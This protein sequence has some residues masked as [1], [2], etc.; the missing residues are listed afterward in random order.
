MFSRI[1][2]L[3]LCVGAC[4]HAA[5]VD[6]PGPA[7]SREFGAQVVA[8]PN[9][10]IVVADPR[11]DADRGAVHLYS[12]RGE[13]ISTL[14]GAAAGDGLGAGDIVVLPS[15]NFLIANQG[16]SN[17]PVVA[18][19]SVTWVNGRS[20]LNGTVSSLNSLVGRRDVDRVGSAIVVLRNG[21]YLVLSPYWDR[22]DGASVLRDAGALTWGSGEA[23]VA[24]AVSVA[25]S[26]VGRSQDDAVGTAAVELGSGHVAVPVPDWDGD[27]ARDVGAVAW[28]DGANG[29]AGEVHAGNALIGSHYGD[30]VGARLVPL[31]GDGG[32]YVA[33]ETWGDGSAAFGALTWCS[34]S[35]PC[36]DTV[37]A[38]NSIIGSTPGDLFDAS[39]LALPDGR[40]LAL[41]PGWNEPSTQAAAAGAI[42][43]L[44]ADRS[45]VGHL[46]PARLLHGTR[47]GDNIG[48]SARLLDNG[49]AVVVSR[50]RH[51]GSN[52]D[53][54]MVSFIDAAAPAVG[55][56]SEQN[57][58]VVDDGASLSVATLAS[59]RYVVACPRCDIDGVPDAGAVAWADSHGV[60][61]RIG[62]GNALH[63]ISPGDNVGS[64]V[65]ALGNGNYVVASPH[66]GRSILS[67]DV[68]AAT[69]V[70]GSNGIARNSATRGVAVS[71]SNS[72]TG[73]QRGDLVGAGAVLA[74]SNGNYV[75]GS[76]HWSN[77]AMADVGAVTWANGNE[78][79]SGVVDASNSL[80]GGSAGDRVGYSV[81]ALA[82]GNYAVGAP[83]WDEHLPSG[84]VVVDGGAA[85]WVDGTR[86][87]TGLVGAGNA[88]LSA[89]DAGARIGRL[90]ALDNGDYVVASAS[91]D[92]C[93][94]A[95]CVLDAGAWT[96]GMA[97]RRLRGRVGRG[98]SVLGTVGN[99]GPAQ[100]FAYDAAS[101]TLVVG[102][103]AANAISLLERS[104]FSD[105]FD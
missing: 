27:T 19:G 31:G 69:W 41:L 74:L 45:L 88:L 42:A 81:V 14:R 16:A 8:L 83:E 68:G 91:A 79:I 29:G 67:P 37:S 87:L 17:G 84:A 85:T 66:W 50:H 70:N 11:F 22:D 52:I 44:P 76:H 1:L 61:G 71:S 59:G 38:A 28:L 64:S 7:G 46:D 95:G 73:A 102:R 48:G 77:G 6:I 103:P 35:M 58:L 39:G 13:R 57:A 54:G 78:G 25:N 20:G 92:S 9:G 24:G 49:N 36:A 32:Y 89:G 62:S 10:N 2:P 43:V 26:L 100:R 3:A 86:G 65:T 47:A 40:M 90:I 53:G 55:A 23:G 30:R 75:V 72:L 101:D 51:D 56:A 96:P 4:A 12:P 5:Q 21:N 98:N 63:G 15:G 34:G 99:E 97:S 94:T 104:L 33:S 18:A 105:G 93:A 80:V 60:A 82:S